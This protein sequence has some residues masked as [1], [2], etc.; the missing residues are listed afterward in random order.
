MFEFKKAGV[1]LIGLACM[2]T[3]VLFSGCSSD[4]DDPAPDPYKTGGEAIATFR[5]YFYNAEGVH[6]FKR[7]NFLET[8]W[9]VPLDDADKACLLFNNITGMDV[10]LTDK[11][12]YT[13]RSEDGKC[14]I[15]MEGQKVPVD[16]VYGT[17]YVDIPACPEIHTVLLVTPGYFENANEWPVQWNH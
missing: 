5:S 13:Y 2:V 9:G 8:E 7:D 16:A 1:R 6:A 15:R 12:N 4:N 14:S 3:V 11:Y 10:K 17:M